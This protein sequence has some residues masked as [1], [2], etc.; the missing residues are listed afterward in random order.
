M[1]MILK[2]LK[3]QLQTIR[4]TTKNWN[5][6]WNFTHVK[7]YMYKILYGI[8]EENLELNGAIGNER[9]LQMKISTKP[10]NS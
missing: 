9:E 7:F 6:M 4:R 2:L 10:L 8:F 5:F 1:N 3:F